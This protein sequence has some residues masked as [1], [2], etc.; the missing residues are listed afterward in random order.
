MI[1][2]ILSC[3]VEFG[4]MYCV[5]FII[6]FFICELIEDFVEFIIEGS[7]DEFNEEVCFWV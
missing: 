5:S 2:V 3:E 1:N 6:I 4:V 7:C